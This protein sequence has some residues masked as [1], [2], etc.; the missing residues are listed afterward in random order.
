MALV[1]KI[2]DR[3]VNIEFNKEFIKVINEKIKKQDTHF[4]ANSLK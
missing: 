1:K 2:K 4:L 3:K